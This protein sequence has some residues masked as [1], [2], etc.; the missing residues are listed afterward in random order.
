VAGSAAKANFSA[1]KIS[2]QKPVC[3][4]RKCGAAFFKYYLKGEGE[5]DLPK[6]TIFISGSNDWKK[7]QRMAPKKHRS[8]KHCISTPMASYRSKLPQARPALMST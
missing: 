8:K 1:T 3:G 5:L 6:A 2:V 7:I 4:L